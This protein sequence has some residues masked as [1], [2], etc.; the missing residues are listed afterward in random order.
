MMQVTTTFKTL[1]LYYCIQWRLGERNI[2]KVPAC[3]VITMNGKQ[4]HVTLLRKVNQA[5][6]DCLDNLITKDEVY[7]AP[8]KVREY[9]LRLINTQTR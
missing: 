7:I 5:L 4:A 6:G 3:K 9:T 8:T 1:V 2:V